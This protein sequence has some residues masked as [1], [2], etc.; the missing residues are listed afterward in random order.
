MDV[1]SGI[2][3]KAVTEGI[4]FQA[5]GLL[6]EPNYLQA[7]LIVFLLFV[8]LMTLARLRRMYVNWSLKGA[9]AMIGLGFFLALILEGF[10]LIGGRTMFTELLGW[11]DA[12]KPI[13]TA[14]EV[15]R[16][17]LVDVLGVTEQVPS[18]F[19]DSGVSSEQVVQA[20]QSLPPNDADTVKTI[21]CS[22]D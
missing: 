7:G 15:G 11:K 10:L 2:A 13:S 8:L 22:Q 3:Q 18:S 14:L 9:W 16:G 1:A 6:F 12:P 20:F 5:F 19:A 21:I 4:E 17:K